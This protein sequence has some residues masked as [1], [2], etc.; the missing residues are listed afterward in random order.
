MPLRDELQR[1]EI[2]VRAPLNVAVAPENRKFNLSQDCKVNQRRRRTI[3]KLRIKACN[4][5]YNG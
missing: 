1:R 4:N 5:P 2:W 3:R